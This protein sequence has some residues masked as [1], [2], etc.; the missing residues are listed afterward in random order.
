[1]L[2]QFIQMILTLKPTSKF[3]D[4]SELLYTLIFLSLF[5]TQ[6]KKYEVKEEEDI[7]QTSQR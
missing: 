3:H 5:H 4:Q 7:F 2:P 1:M 6:W